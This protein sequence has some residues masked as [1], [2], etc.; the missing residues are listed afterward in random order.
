MKGRRQYLIKIIECLQFLGRQGIPIQGNTE[1]QSNFIQLLKLRAQ[2]NPFIS[3]WLNSKE[4]KYTNHDIQN[5]IFE[6]M[7][8]NVICD[9]VQDIRTQSGFYSIISDEYTDITN[10][11]QLTFCLRWVDKSL[12]AH[13]YFLGF[14]NI[15]NISSETIVVKDALVRH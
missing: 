11:E 7:A 13:E 8:H 4:E 9:I 3:K 6:I 1:D 10:K 15:P 14:Y 2:D 12:E 5:E